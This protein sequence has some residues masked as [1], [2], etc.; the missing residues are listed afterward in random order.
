M[1]GFRL[2]RRRRRPGTA[3]WQRRFHRMLSNR[4]LWPAM[5]GIALAVGLGVQIGESAI[6]AINP[7]HFQGAA[8]PPQAIDPNAPPPSADPSFAGGYG[9]AD[10]QAARLADGAIPAQD[11]DYVPQGVTLRPAAEPSWQAPPPPPVSMAPWPRGQ[12]SAHPQIE[13]YVDFPIE[14]KPVLHSAPARALSVEPPTDQADPQPDD[15]P[16]AAGK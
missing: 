13:R 10:G 16:S 8:P 15:P 14:D 5:I 11:F 9:W 4:A 12:V 2:R 6:G 1:K 3:R 7:I